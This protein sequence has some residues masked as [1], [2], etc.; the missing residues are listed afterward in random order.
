MAN[1]FKGGLFKSGEEAV[2][3]TTPA[4][5]PKAA[6][7]RATPDEDF[8]TTFRI[9]RG[10][11]AELQT[12]AAELQTREGHARPDVSLVLRRVLKAWVAEGRKVPSP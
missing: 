6:A 3:A 7:K 1:Q 4:P 11:H 8:T 5:H 2:K 12:A 9:T 10:L